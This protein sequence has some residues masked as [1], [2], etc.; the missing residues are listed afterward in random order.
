M[1]IQTETT[2]NEDSLKFI[3]G[4]PVME[5]GTAEFLDTRA[6]LVSPLALRLF[7]IDGVKAVLYGP[8]FVTVTKEGGEG[9]P[10]AVIKPDAYS[11]LME[12]ISA[13]SAAAASSSGSGG[14][15]LSLIPSDEC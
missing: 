10:W 4:T 11:I 8:D 1:F 2:P 7:G 12:H 9:H 6:A 15:R 14:E 5:T 3:P 13:A